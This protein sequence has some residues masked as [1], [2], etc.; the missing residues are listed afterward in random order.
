MPWHPS[1]PTWAVPK[2]SREVCWMSRHPLLGEA[3]ERTKEKREY[4]STITEWQYFLKLISLTVFELISTLLLRLVSKV[5]LLQTKEV[6]WRKDR[7]RRTCLRWISKSQQDL[8]KHSSCLIHA[9][10]LWQWKEVQN[11]ERKKRLN[12]LL[13]RSGPAG[14]TSFRSTPWVMGDHVGGSTLN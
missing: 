10:E 3:E 11:L 5:P 14:Q 2:R 12:H 6:K 4:K 13:F 8:E 1:P 9:P 7:G